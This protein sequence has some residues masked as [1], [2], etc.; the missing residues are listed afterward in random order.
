MFCD[1]QENEW[2]S[3]VIMFREINQTLK[4]DLICPLSNVEA[5]N[6]KKDDLAVV[7]GQLGKG[8]SQAK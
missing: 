2:N 5:G 3:Q 6:L 8:D 7:E 4:D 1:L